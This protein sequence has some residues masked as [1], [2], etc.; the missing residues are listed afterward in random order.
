M[1]KVLLLT[2]CVM[3]ALP[4]MA[5][6][7]PG[8][9]FLGACGQAFVFAIFPAPP[10][11]EICW[12]E[13]TGSLIGGNFITGTKCVPTDSCGKF[14]FK[15]HCDHEVIRLGTRILGNAAYFNGMFRVCGVTTTD[16]FCDPAQATWISGLVLNMF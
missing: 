15:L 14:C 3:L 8:P 1:K 2:L 11:A 7:D 10:P 6:A 4:V 9:G 12:Y 13:C 5:M 16:V